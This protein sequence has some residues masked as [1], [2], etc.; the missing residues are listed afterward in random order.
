MPEVVTDIS[1]GTM[2]VGV[3]LV[4][5]LFLL[6]FNIIFIKRLVIK[7]DKI[8]IVSDLVTGQMPLLSQRVTEMENTIKDLSRDLRDIGLLKERTAVLEYA[9][10]IKKDQS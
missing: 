6:S 5:I 2:I 1:S 9:L 8:D 3:A 4:I 7:I 10:N